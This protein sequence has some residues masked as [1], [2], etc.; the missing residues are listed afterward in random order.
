MVEVGMVGVVVSGSIFC[1]GGLRFTLQIVVV[2]VKVYGWT[3]N[4]SLRDT[5]KVV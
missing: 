1:D 4:A 2:V 3:S 5:N